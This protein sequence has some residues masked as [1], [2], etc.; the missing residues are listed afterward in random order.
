MHPEEKIDQTLVGNYV[1]V[2]R[3]LNCFGVARVPRTN[4]TVRRARSFSTSVTNHD[5][6]QFISK[7]STVMML[8]T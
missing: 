3:D 7:V 4:L 6:V 2:K 5:F 8:G 1:W